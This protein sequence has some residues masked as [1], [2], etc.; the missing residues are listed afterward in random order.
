MR[1]LPST[2][3]F[4]AVFCLTWL[5]TLWSAGT[6]RL[7]HMCTDRPVYTSGATQLSLSRTSSTPGTVWSAA[8]T[9][10]SRESCLCTWRLTCLW[11]DVRIFLHLCTASELNQSLQHNKTSTIQSMKLHCFCT[12][13]SLAPVVGTSS[14]RSRT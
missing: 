5:R 9:T 8:V 2:F 10:L 3:T 11:S 7:R 4:A 13:A 6:P 14:A 12:F 1:H